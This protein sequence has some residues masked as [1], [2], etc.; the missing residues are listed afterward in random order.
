[1]SKKGYKH[2]EESKKKMSEAKKGKKHTEESK[3]KM[4][5][6][7]KGKKMK[8]LSEETKKKLSDAKK[9]KK[10]KPFT[11]ETKKKMSEAKKGKKMKP[12]SEEA[13]KK[14]SEAKKGYK[15]TEE[16]KRKLSEVNKGKKH[17]EATKR[18][19]SEALKGEK[20]YLWKGGISFEPY[21]LEFNEDL[22]E[23]IR[24]RDR[25]KCQL[26]EK[27][28]LEN[29]KKL[30]THHIDYCKTNNDPKNLISLCN[31]CHSKTNT[32][33]DYWIN[34]ISQKVGK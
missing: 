10:I 2:S 11:E 24:N 33:R 18:K 34:L 8:P 15:H 14:M 4:S 23:V 25:R 13:K 30:D 26:C 21:G 12:H 28:E 9:G 17:I 5:D 3:K 19:I 22:K 7:K 27:T 29:K 31:N 1:M 32:N 20:S 6:A 16:A